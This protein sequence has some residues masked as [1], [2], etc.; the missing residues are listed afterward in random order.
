MSSIKVFN[1][2]ISLPV[3]LL[4]VV[5][6][7]ICY[8]SLF[9]A[10]MIRFHDAGGIQYAKGEL[11]SI[12][13]SSALIS[14]LV[15]LV[16][17]AMGLYQA[18]RREVIWNVLNRIT[19]AFI[20]ASLALSIIFFIFPDMYFGRGLFVLSLFISFVGIVFARVVFESWVD[21]HTMNKKVLVLGVGEKAEWINNLRRRSDQRGISIVGFYSPYSEEMHVD[22]D[23]V[24]S[25]ELNLDEYVLQ[26]GIVESNDSCTS[27]CRASTEVETF[28]LNLGVQ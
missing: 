23:R 21:K 9:A 14:V 4:V 18:Q 12:Q 5:E 11:V 20:V 16:M 1:H 26:N 17:L 19:T 28:S 15:V 25:T 8:V 3:A 13:A 27:D 2:H 22:E 6:A 24:I 10:S 7:S